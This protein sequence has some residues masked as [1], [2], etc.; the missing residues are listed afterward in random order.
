MANQDVPIKAEPAPQP[1]PRPLAKVAVAAAAV[2]GVLVVAGV[3]VAAIGGTGNKGD[4]SAP[5]PSGPGAAA[6][7]GS[8]PVSSTSVACDG[9]KETD[10]NKFVRIIELVSPKSVPLNWG[11]CNGLTCGTPDNAE[12]V[13]NLW[14]PQFGSQLPATVTIH[15]LGPGTEITGVW[16]GAGP[17]PGD[18]KEVKDAKTRVGADGTVNVDL[19]ALNAMTADLARAINPRF[20]QVCGVPEREKDAIADEYGTRFD[21][22]QQSVIR[23]Q[24]QMQDLNRTIEMM[25]N[26]VNELNQTSKAIIINIGSR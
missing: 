2:V 20:K 21:N 7:V 23:I 22:T 5:C 10:D 3:A 18:L 17:S 15:G 11:Y 14:I 24:I 4:Y 8:G 1:K 13:S 12:C 25:S 9:L 26:I 19:S 16:V 6:V